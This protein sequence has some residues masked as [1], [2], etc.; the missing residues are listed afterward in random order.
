[1]IANNAGFT[2]RKRFKTK[3]RINKGI[4]IVN[5]NFRIT[6]ESGRESPVTQTRQKRRLRL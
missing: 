1:M 6:D 5:I 3:D 4:A 2:C